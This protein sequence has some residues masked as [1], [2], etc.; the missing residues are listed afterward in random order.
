MPACYEIRYA[1]G[2]VEET[3]GIRGLHYEFPDGETLDVHTE[4]GWCF[5]CNTFTDIERLEAIE[6]IDQQIA[7]M[8]DPDSVLY[9]MFFDSPAGKD[10]EFL[11]SQVAEAQ[12]RRDFLLQRTSPAKCVHCGTENVKQIPHGETVE[13]PAGCGTFVLESVGMCS[14]DFMN[15]YFT[16]EGERIPRDTRPSYW[17]HPSLDRDR[18]NR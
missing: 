7:D 14:T 10:G 12:R 13:H 2:R 9:R 5:S 16:P 18:T 4:I 17:Y 11:K 1:D 3:F 15:W 8:H 6:E